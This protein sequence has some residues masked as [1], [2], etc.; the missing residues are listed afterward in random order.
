MKAIYKVPRKAAKLVKVENTL[1][2]LQKAVGGYIEC[3]TLRDGGVLICDEEGL[4]KGNVLF[5][6]KV[7][8]HMIFGPF[9]IVGQDGEEFTDVPDC[10]IDALG[11]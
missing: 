6:Q 5:N 3:V 2:A 10:Y 7:E 8:G 11:K 1:E 4:L 9:L